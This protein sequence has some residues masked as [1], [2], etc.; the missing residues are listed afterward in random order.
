MN[1]HPYVRAYMAG[2]VV[3][4]LFMLV[5][6]ASFCVARFIYNVDVPVERV[7]VFPLALVPNLWGVWN[8]CWVSLHS[9]RRLPLGIHGALL[10]AVLLPLAFFAARALSTELPGYLVATFWVALPGLLVIY[11]LFWKYV[12]G[13]FNSM[14]GIAS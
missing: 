10:P 11:Y 6:F 3:P 5:I 14:L 9:R 2:L 8:M 1:T 13:F 7:I 4:S 12:V